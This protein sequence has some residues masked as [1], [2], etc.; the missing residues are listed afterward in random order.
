MS[1]AAAFTVSF[2]LAWPAW[3]TAESL[4]AVFS[5]VWPVANSRQAK[6]ASQKGRPN[7]AQT[8]TAWNNLVQTPPDGSAWTMIIPTAS[9]VEKATQ[10]HNKRPRRP[11]SDINQMHTDLMNESQKWLGRHGKTANWTLYTVLWA[12]AD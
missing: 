1:G 10:T 2:A 4:L 8:L 7:N 5:P 9:G 11:V 6:R 12:G 3:N